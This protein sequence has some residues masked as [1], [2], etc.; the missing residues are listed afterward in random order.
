MNYLIDNYT[1]GTVV[2]KYIYIQILNI[3]IYCNT[4]YNQDNAFISY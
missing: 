4:P 2:D 1:S 3:I